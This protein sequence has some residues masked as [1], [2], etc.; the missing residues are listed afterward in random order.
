VKKIIYVLTLG[1]LTI[2][3]AFG[4]NTDST[5]KANPINGIYLELGG[6]SLLYGINYER[7]ITNIG[8]QTIAT[9][10]GYGFSYSTLGV[11]NDI[12][13]PIEVKLINGIGKKSHFEYGLG[14]TCFYQS[15][16][17]D[18]LIDGVVVPQSKYRM[19]NFVRIGYRYTSQK[20]FLFRIGLTPLISSNSEPMV[21]L[22]GGIS[23]GY[24]F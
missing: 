17:P 10:F 22:F 24:C 5:L 7:A 3:N 23:L 21:N 1:L 15:D 18:K 16:R 2:L 4:R 19:V 11:F 12:V 6:N 13:I 20:G 8:K 14:A 9:S